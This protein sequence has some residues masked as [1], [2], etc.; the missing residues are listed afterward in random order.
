MAAGS[1]RGWNA[2]FTLFGIV[3]GGYQRSLS[4]KEALWSLGFCLS[5]WALAP[6]MEMETWERAATTRPKIGAGASAGL[7]VVLAALLNV[8]LVHALPFLPRFLV[9][10]NGQGQPAWQYWVVDAA[11]P[12]M[13]RWS[14][15]NSLLMGGLALILVALLGRVA[16]L[17]AWLASYATAIY[18]TGI[19]GLCAVSPDGTC[20]P[21]FDYNPASWHWPI[22]A[23]VSLAAVAIWGATGAVP[24]LGLGTV[25]RRLLARVS[26]N[27]A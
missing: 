9:P 27:N 3:E 19:S 4:V 22:T 18:V 14:L 17:L 6:Q 7:L 10:T 21:T 11:V 13:T 5:A 16:G 2:G 12:T 1:A 26:G 23:A 8:A 15:N 20:L 24:G 25:P